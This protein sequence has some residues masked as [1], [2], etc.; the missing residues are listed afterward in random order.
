M[1]KTPYHMRCVGLI[2]DIYQYQESFA[3]LNMCSRPVRC[4]AK[5]SRI[6]PGQYV[7]RL[8]CSFAEQN[9]QPSGNEE[10]KLLNTIF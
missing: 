7:E 5:I 9:S 4:P 1:D 6:P 10:K 3:L 8:F 2:D